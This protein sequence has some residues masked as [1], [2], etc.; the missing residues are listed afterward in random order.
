MVDNPSWRGGRP[1][2]ACHPGAL[3][4]GYVLPGLALSVS[5]AAKDLGVSRQTLHRIL[6]GSASVTAEMA[7]RLETLTGMSSMFWLR[8]Q[9]EHDIERARASLAGVLSTIPRH[10]LPRKIMKQIGALD[11]R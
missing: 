10:T 7:T 4:R 8:L 5:Q 3:L 2:A 6:D 1:G 11:E 9:C